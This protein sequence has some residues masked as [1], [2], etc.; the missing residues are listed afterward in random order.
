MTADG[1]TEGQ[2]TASGDDGPVAS[3][4]IPAH[5]EASVIERCLRSLLHQS[6]PGELEIVVACNGCQDSTPDLA[7]SV[8]PSITVVETP[9]AS[10]WGA[11]N[12]GDEHAAT[13]P[14]VY[15][16]ADVELSPRA[17]QDLAAALERTG[18]L[19]GAP[20]L[21]WPAGARGVVGWYYRMW[22][23][24]PYF[25][26]GFMGLG[27]YGM[28]EAG[29]RRFGEFPETMAED[30]LILSLFAPDERLTDH[31][32]WFA[33]LLPT[34]LRELVRVQARQRAANRKLRREQPGAVPG[35]SSRWLLA[36]AGSPR[37]WP[38]VVSFL[39]VRA[40]A[41]ILAAVRLRRNDQRWTRDRS[42][43]NRATADDVSVAGRP[44]PRA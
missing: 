25:S 5:D 38:E 22:Q 32:S 2:V 21:R 27:F 14:R 9:V 18:R 30:F 15:L 12:L 19:A 16:D 41:E 40:A 6:R 35:A 43:R 29:R 42:S 1:P 13:F 4:V 3:V 37:A 24:S 31:S 8:D 26:D 20:A 44:E 7:R 11:L 17:V 36:M 23:R 28:T 39:G 10:K 34:S 33:P